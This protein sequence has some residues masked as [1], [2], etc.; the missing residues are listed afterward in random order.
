MLADP[1]P[2]LIIC[3]EGHRLKKTKSRTY[4]ALLTLRTRRRV[5][6]I[7]I[8]L[9]CIEVFY[10]LVR[11]AIG[12]SHRIPVSKSSQ[13]VRGVASFCAGVTRHRN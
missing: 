7:A 9:D 6:T 2:D 12:G 11:V 13:R 10:E 4:T 3:D 8:R 5:C 1:G